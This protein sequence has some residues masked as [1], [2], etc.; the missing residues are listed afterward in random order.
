VPFGDRR[1]ALTRGVGQIPAPA[2]QTGIGIEEVRCRGPSKF[3]HHCRPR[4]LNVDPHQIG[5]RHTPHDALGE[6]K[7]ARGR[8]AQ[9]VA[10]SCLVTDVMAEHEDRVGGFHRMGSNCSVN[11]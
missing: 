3:F 1:R 5:L 6:S 11:G 2:G 8:S 9:Q 7:E 10:D 4:R